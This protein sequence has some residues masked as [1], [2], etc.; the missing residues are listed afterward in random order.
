MILKGPWPFAHNVFMETKEH[1]FL[2]TLILSFYL[3]IAAR[4]QLP[5]SAAARRMVLCVAVLIALSGLAMEG[6]GAVI[7]HGVKV[8]LL[9]PSDA[10]AQ[11]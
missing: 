9:R 8:A 6:S 11:K 7:D 3:P 10:G 2:M 1:L 5:S 4:D